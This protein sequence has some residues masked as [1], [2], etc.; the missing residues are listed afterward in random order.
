MTNGPRPAPV[1]PL[2]LVLL[3]LPACGTQEIASNPLFIGDAT[4]GPNQGALLIDI[5]PP[6]AT[7]EADQAR[8]ASNQSSPQYHVFIDGR[9]VVWNADGFVW[10]VTIGDGG[11]FGAGYQD[12]GATTSTSAATTARC[13]TAM[14]S[15][16]PVRSITSICTARA[17]ASGAPWCHTRS[18]RRPAWNTS[19]SST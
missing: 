5:G 2:A 11:E 16:P 14:A 3:A 12:A 13:S 19:A 6:D 18:R 4:P 8:A 7:Y 15:W 10:A 9:Q 1:V 17:A